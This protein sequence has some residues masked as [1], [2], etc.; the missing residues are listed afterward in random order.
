MVVGEQKGRL[1]RASRE[2]GILG[3]GEQTP[4][5]TVRGGKPRAGPTCLTHPVRGQDA[6]MNGHLGP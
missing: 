3:T 6:G 4:L 1:S 5:V 2:H